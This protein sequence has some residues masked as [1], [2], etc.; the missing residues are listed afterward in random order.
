MLPAALVQGALVDDWFV[1]K[2]T[3]DVAQGTVCFE[4]S[5]TTAS[6]KVTKLRLMPV[7]QRIRFFNQV[8]D[9]VDEDRRAVDTCNVW[10]ASI[11][12]LFKRIRNLRP[13]ATDALQVG[14]LTETDL[15]MAQAG[16][17]LPLKIL[18]E[19]DPWKWL[20]RQIGQFAKLCES[21][22]EAGHTSAEVGHY[23]SICWH[24]HFW[25]LLH[26]YL[27]RARN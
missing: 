6:G 24:V 2:V 22:F 27:N 5:P 12:A 13:V 23:A 25:R 9:L 21:S 10:P 7:D 1:L 19:I 16:R 26:P 17:W 15:G 20:E 11:R 18:P 14:L 4:W 8:L 3:L